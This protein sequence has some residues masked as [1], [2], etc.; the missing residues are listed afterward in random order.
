MWY[1]GASN[2]GSNEGCS[3]SK[4]KRDMTPVYLSTKRR[5]KMWR[6]TVTGEAREKQGIHYSYVASLGQNN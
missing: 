2:E 1:E 4:R 6:K 5:R 3:N